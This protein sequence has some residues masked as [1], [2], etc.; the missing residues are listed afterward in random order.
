MAMTV[1]GELSPCPYFSPQGFPSYFLPLVLLRRSEIQPFKWNLT[2]GNDSF[3]IYFT[4]SPLPLKNNRDL[5]FW[6]F[7]WIIHSK[8]QELGF[9]ASMLWNGKKGP[10]VMFIIIIYLSSFSGKT[11][12]SIFKYFNS[13]VYFFLQ[14]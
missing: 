5:Y 10:K 2:F 6:L 12:Q 1:T 14:I 3:S 13:L 11:I 9:F 8:I 7:K 4:W